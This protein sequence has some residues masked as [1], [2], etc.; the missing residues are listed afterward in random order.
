MDTTYRTGDYYGDATSNHIW[1]TRDEHGNL[2]AEL[3]VSTERSEIMNIAVQDEH[4]GQGH[5][6]RLYETASRQMDIY[7][8]PAAHRSPEGDAFAEA[9]GGDT[10]APYPCDCHA[11]QEDW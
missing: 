3:Y 9:V 1:E 10:V 5:A 7:H 4:Q 11:C 8:A 6:R 2:V